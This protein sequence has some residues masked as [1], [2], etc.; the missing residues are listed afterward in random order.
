M[1]RKVIDYVKNDEFEIKFDNRYINVINF[2]NISYMEDSKIKINYNEG[3]VLIKG[4][5]LTVSKLLD[6]EILIKG[7]FT[8]IEFRR[9]YE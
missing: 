7:K 3:S 6:N 2:S 9:N 1:I 8:N 4:N 5:E